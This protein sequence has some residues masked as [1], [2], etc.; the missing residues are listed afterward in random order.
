[1]PALLDG[2]AASDGDYSDIKTEG[3]YRLSFGGWGDGLLDDLPVDLPRWWSPQRDALLRSTVR[4]CGMWGCAV[5]TA[6]T[7]VTSK[8]YELSGDVPLRKQ[9]G[10]DLLRYSDR[11]NGWV[12][13]L[14]KI[15]KDYCTTDNG[16]FIEIVHQT[17][18]AGSRIVRLEVLDSLR[19]TRTGDIET[20]VLY[21]D[22]HGHYHELQAHQII[23]FV[24]MPSS[25][26][27]WNGVGLCAA[28]R[29]YTAILKLS[30][31]DRYLIEK[32]TGRRALAVNFISGIS[33][34]TL[35]SIVTTAKDDAAA[36][37]IQH[38]MGMILAAVGGDRPVSNVQINLAELPDGFN[39]KE[40]WDIA[41][42]TMANALGI[43]IQD[44]Q[45]MSGQG[46][47]TGAQSQV[48]NR[49][50]KQKGLATLQQQ[51][52][53]KLNEFV[54]ARGTTFA[55]SDRD[56][57]DQAAE[58]EINKIST[59]DVALLVERGIITPVQAAQIKVDN[60]QLPDYI[61]PAGD[62]TEDMTITDADG[63]PAEPDAL[64]PDEVSTNV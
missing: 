55:W 39:R 4:L 34:K 11:R 19:C 44:L 28:S 41:L 12:S 42:L 20:P 57:A 62:A 9:R 24:D 6:T 8:G 47:G 21:Q 53:H 54:L 63:K 49:K 2:Q 50:A 37:G 1:M 43:D 10:D 16:A 27:T 32:V 3:A 46:L 33:P 48:L 56:Y 45:P 38:Y 13:F 15:I 58:A 64:L 35:E 40:E 25:D 59:D 31:M 18:A 23:D 52:V 14:G 61:L 36:K 30:A 7:Q 22:K 29:A 5:S 17:S 51:L 60:G 26:A